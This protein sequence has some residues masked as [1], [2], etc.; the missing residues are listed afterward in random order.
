MK[1]KE[2]IKRILTQKE[3][4][5]EDKV[6]AL[7]EEKKSGFQGLLSDEGAALLVAQD[8]TVEIE[9]DER[10]E[11]LQVTDLI[12]NLNDVTI[13]GRVLSVWPLR[14][15][16]KRDGNIGKYV[17][18]VLA[19]KT[20][21]IFCIFWDSKAEKISK[22]ETLQGKMLK[23]AHG[24]TREGI[25]KDV[26]LHIGDRGDH[27]ISPNVSEENYPKFDERELKFSDISE[28][29]SE[30]KNINVLAKVI[31]IGSVRKAENSYRKNSF[32][33]VL[34]GNKDGIIK[35]Y[36]WEDKAELL[37]KMKEG[38][39]LLI[40]K[41]ITKEKFGRIFLTVNRLSSIKINPEDFRSKEV[42]P[43]K[44]DKIGVLKEKQRLANVEGTVVEKPVV[45]EVKTKM[46]EKI[47]LA[48]FIIDDD[49]GRAKV[50]LWRDLANLA[51]NLDLGNRVR[52]TGVYPREG[53]NDKELEVSSDSL[54]FIEKIS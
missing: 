45:K 15:F 29:K 42:M 4:L 17:R 10:L 18:L 11:E 35:A 26:E 25:S 3:E 40:Q 23:I 20:G 14:E 31:K 43:L 44:V 53:L 41:A 47:K 22:E 8:L 24:Y 7:I 13:I 49:S 30:R 36:L 32:G 51:N 54:T 2:I 37:K 33:T 12:S 52:V 39:I 28:I 38:D 19:D 21:K 16:T 5:S 34:L 50:L 9:Q 46:G 1:F 48:S 6:Q 27:I